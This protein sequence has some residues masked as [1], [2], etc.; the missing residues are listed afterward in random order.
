MRQLQRGD[1]RSP[2]ARATAAFK[3]FA[4][5]LAGKIRHLSDLVARIA[6]TDWPSDRI[7]YE[8]YGLKEDEIAIVE[9][10][11]QGQ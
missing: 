6:A 5:L 3:D 9:G 2:R 10:C 11:S 4:K 7:V 1:G 8:L